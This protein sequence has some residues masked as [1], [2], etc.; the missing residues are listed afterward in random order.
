MPAKG[1]RLTEK[2]T[3]SSGSYDVIVAGGGV[4]GLACAWRVARDGHSVLVLERGRIASGA[5]GVAAGMLAP[6]GEASWGE[7]ALLALGLDSLR[8]WDEF[9][10]ELE[11]ESAKPAGYR[12]T[13]ALHLALD[14][15]EAEELNRRYEL[16]RDLGLVSER[17]TPSEARALEPSLSPSVTAALHAPEEAA[18]DPAILC[19]ALAAA[20]RARGGEIA[21]GAELAGVEVG[22]GDVTVHLA[23]GR[24][25]GAERLVVATGAWSGAAEWLPAELR[26]PV[27]P[28]KGEILTLRDRSGEPPCGRILA[29]ERIYL[30]P[31]ADGRLI[32]GA[33]V[34]EL[35]FDETVTAGGVLELLREAYRLLPEVAELELVEARARLRPGTPDNRPIIG[36]AGG[37][38][39]GPVILATGHYRNGI[40][41]APA[42]A[43]AVAA[44]LRGEEPAIDADAFGPGRFGIGA[45]SEVAT[46]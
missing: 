37:A 19:D 12:R 40:L 36:N 42:T 32:A 26:P 22:A 33:T 41:L 35:G 30:V 20:I 8:R 44:L 46:R 27:R 4:I 17:L 29:H 31:R 23:D 10:A 39:G 14:R 15:D 38:A 11:A 43:D 6:V 45:A 1:A 21:E 34:E 13:G 16:H 3:P 5:S 28:V 2:S 7:E 18:A 24:E 25:L 9:G